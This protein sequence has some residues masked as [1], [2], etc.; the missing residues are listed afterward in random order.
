M[1]ELVNRFHTTMVLTQ[2]RV[3]IHHAH[4]SQFPY[5]Y[6]SHATKCM[7]G[8]LIF[9]I[10][11]HTTMVLTQLYPVEV[12]NRNEKCF[13]TTMVLTQPTF[14]KSG[15]TLPSFHTTMVLTQR[16]TNVSK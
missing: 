12:S 16:I 9:I 3:G 4:G 5:H 10:S 8:L 1:L 14:W 6:G 7:G 2:R 15:R 13:H 11:F